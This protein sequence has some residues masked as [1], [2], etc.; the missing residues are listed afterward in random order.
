MARGAAEFREHDF[1]AWLRGLAPSP[2]LIVPVGDDAAFIEP[3]RIGGQLLAL[4]TV[5]EGTHAPVGVESDA[6]LARKVV[7][8]NVSDMAAMGG[9]PDVALLSLKLGRDAD[10]G[11]ARRIME[12]IV[13][14]CGRFGIVLAG[15]D[16][17][18]GDGGVVLSLALTGHP[19]GEPVRRDGA[20]I[21]DLVMVTGSFGG[22]I[23]GK[24]GDFEPRLAEAEALVRLGPPSAMIDVSDGLLR[25]LANVAELSGFGAVVD[26]AAVP[27]ADAARRLAL[28]S[29]KTPLDHAL[30]DGEDFELLFTMAADRADAVLSAWNSPTPLAVVGRIVKDGLWLAA[31]G[32]VR[33]VDPGGYDHRAAST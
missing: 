22:S 12:C 7:R 28:H 4:D 29:G 14:E 5:V 23:L 24:H 25:D 21:D 17:V 18:V 26:A 20:K 1:L 19:I 11:R 10:A 13:A 31:D 27:I 2:R 30:N 32:A 15:G 9:I 6:I 3:R 33:A 16:T 8:C